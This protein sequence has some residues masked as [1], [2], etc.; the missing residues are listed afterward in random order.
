MIKLYNYGTEA[1]FFKAEKLSR[2]PR[3]PYDQEVTEHILTIFEPDRKRSYS[4][5]LICTP[6][7]STPPLISLLSHL[8]EVRK[9]HGEVD[10]RCV[11]QSYSKSNI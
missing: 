8:K 5:D 6:I 4:T 7:P 1:D 3:Y 2:Y 10:G 9:N 11:G